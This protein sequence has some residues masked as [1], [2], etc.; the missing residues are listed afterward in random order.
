[1]TM[2]PFERYISKLREYQP[3]IKH[4]PHEINWYITKRFTGTVFSMLMAIALIAPLIM[5][6][7]YAYAGVLLRIIKGATQLFVG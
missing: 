3:N 6:G 7:V 5:L 1:M 4:L 2:P